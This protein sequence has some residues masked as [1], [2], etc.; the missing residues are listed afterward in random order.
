MAAPETKLMKELFETK[1]E[2][3]P[4]TKVEAKAEAKVEPAPAPKPSPVKASPTNRVLPS[5]KRVAMALAAAL[6]AF[7]GIIWG[8]RRIRKTKLGENSWLGKLSKS[9]LLARSK[10][11]EV[12]SSHHLGPKKSIAVVR[13]RGRNYLVGITPESINLISELS[14]EDA[15][16]EAIPEAI[17]AVLKAQPGAGAVAA[18][19]PQ[20]AKT[21]ERAIATDPSGDLSVRERI[22]RSMEGKKVLTQ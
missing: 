9:P 1:P 13:V 8:I 19:K 6:F 22:R 12:V 21:L 4:E 10:W 7:V 16:S 3:K 17:P 14:D 2:A 11:I 18:G 5:L 15:M 20:F